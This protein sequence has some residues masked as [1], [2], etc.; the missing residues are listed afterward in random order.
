MS[1]TYLTYSSFAKQRNYNKIYTGDTFKYHTLLVPYALRNVSI[2]II[3]H[4]FTIF[5]HYINKKRMYI[6]SDYDFQCHI[7]AMSYELFA[8][9]TAIKTDHSQSSWPP[10]VFGQV[11]CLLATANTPRFNSWIDKQPLWLSVGRVMSASLRN[12]LSHVH[13][14]LHLISN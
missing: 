9:P 4:T 11:R 5:L 2:W 12:L 3:I 1:I 13:F 10:G 8:V 7:S 6:N 14:F